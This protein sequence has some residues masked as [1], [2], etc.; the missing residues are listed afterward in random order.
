MASNLHIARCVLDT[1]YL[2]RS[3]IS[4]FVEWNAGTR[5]RS[6]SDTHME[7]EKNGFPDEHYI[8]NFRF[9]LEVIIIFLLFFHLS[10]EEKM[11]K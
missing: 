3:K 4:I 11:S 1:K 2:V 8:R 7:F 9:Y 6:I 5:R 10:C